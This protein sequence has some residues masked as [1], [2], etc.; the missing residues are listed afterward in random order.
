MMMRFGAVFFILCSL[1]FLLGFSVLLSP[2]GAQII[3]TNTP[4]H[5][6]AG[7]IPPNPTLYY[8]PDYT[9]AP[10]PTGIPTAMPRLRPRDPNNEAYEIVNIVLIGHD[11]E[12]IEQRNDVFRTDT[13][14]I[15]NI[16]LSTGT[17][18][19]LSLP[20][21][22]LVWIPNWQMQR[23]NVAWGWGES[24]GWT[25][26]GWGLFRQMALYNLGIELHYYAM[27]DFSGFKTII[28]RLNGVTVAVDCPIQDY[29]FTGDYDAEDNPIFE[30]TTLPIGVHTLDSTEALWYSRSR[31]N[32]SD[33]DRGRRQQQVLRAIFNQGRDLGLITQFPDLWD[34]L[35]SVVSTN[36]PLPLMIE[37][38]PLALQIEPNQIENHFFRLGVETASWQ[39]PDGENVQIP[40]YAMLGLIQNF[41]TPPTVNQVVTDAAKIEIYDASGAEASWDVVA[42]DRLLWEGI[43]ASPLGQAEATQDKTTLI[44][45]TG[46]TKGSSLETLVR[47]LNIN[48][49]DVQ[50]EPDPNRSVD[51]RIV[52]G[53]N[54]NSCVDRQVQAVED[55]PPI[56]PT[57]SDN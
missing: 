45:Y 18:S 33:F 16:N 13:M 40:T 41:L 52:L 44:D 55:L 49:N 15:V 6:P 39:L 34:D 38:L 17:V 35:N 11:S 28:D 27:I 42:A 10:Q 19:M 12:S 31:R 57:P 56:T 5:A 23:I 36:V 9:P 37:L 25:D 48:P 50:F 21:D 43:L 8:P 30:L 46:S 54:Y 32:S 7:E 20:R 1:G 22:L 4:S 3:P 47:V 53:R 26:G 29:L 14:I 51:F 24:V 2:A